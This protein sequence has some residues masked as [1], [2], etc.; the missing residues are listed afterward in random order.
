MSASNNPN[1]LLSRRRFLIRSAKAGV[2]VAA[3]CSAGY[4]FYD[5][6]G[7]I[8]PQEPELVRLPDFAIPATKGRM[9]VAQGPDRVKSLRAA[10][11]DLGGMAAFIKKGDR[12]L[13]KVNAAFASPPALI[14]HNAPAAG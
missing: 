7:A 1:T 4:L 10:L 6:G 13:L 5:P 2:S 14:G 12:V 8:E 3:A 11:N 9:S